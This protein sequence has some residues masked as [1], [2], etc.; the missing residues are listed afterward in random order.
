MDDIEGDPEMRQHI[1]I[2]KRDDFQPDDLNDA[3]DPTF[4]G[5]QITE[6]LENLELDD[7]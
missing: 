3:D 1:N 6:L 5:M 2:Y 7:N 4:Q